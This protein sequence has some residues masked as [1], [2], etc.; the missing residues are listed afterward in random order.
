MEKIYAGFRAMAVND[1]AKKMVN[2]RNMANAVLVVDTDT[3]EVKCRSFEC[4]FETGKLEKCVKALCN[5]ENTKHLSK[6]E[7]EELSK[8]LEERGLKF[9]FTNVC[10]SKSLADNMD[11]VV[12]CICGKKFSAKEVGLN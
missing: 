4:D 11:L 6:D 3:D 1:E 12:D 2:S 10:I 5:N 8:K 7:V 9:Y